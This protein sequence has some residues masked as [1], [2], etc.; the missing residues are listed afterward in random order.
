M[1]YVAIHHHGLLNQLVF[2]Q[3][4]DRHRH[5]VNRAE[6]L[7]VARIGVMKSAADIEADPVAKGQARGQRSAARRQPKR[8]PHG[9]GIGDL[10]VR[11][12]FQGKCAGPQP[13]HPI[14]RMHQHQIVIGGGLGL[15]E[16]IRTR[17]SVRQQA[18]TDQ[19]KLLRW[20]NMRTQIEIVAGVINKFER[21]HVTP[22]IA[23][24]SPAPRNRYHPP[25]S[26][27]INRWRAW[28]GLAGW[29]R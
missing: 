1:V 23:T 2:L 24:R 7:A 11:Q 17:E 5:I 9:F 19:A 26:R 20:E 22:P 3:P 21:K 27:A 14:R 13:L 12:L 10:Q 25:N 18:F 15:D 6:P 28:Q 8:F 16:I 29:D 4:A